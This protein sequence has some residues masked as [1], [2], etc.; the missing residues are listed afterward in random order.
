M[1]GKLPVRVNEVF[2]KTEKGEAI[3]YVPTIVLAECLYLVERGKIALDFS[4][5]LRK[6]EMSNNFIPISFDLDILKLLP[7]IDRLELHDRIIVATAKNLGAKV[8]TKDEEIIKSG[9]VE[10]VW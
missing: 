7:T 4:E 1:V 6:I 3:I 10:V 9:K 8:L 5:I 2:K